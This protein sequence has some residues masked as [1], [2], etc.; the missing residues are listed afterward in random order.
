MNERRLR[1]QFEGRAALSNLQAAEVAQV[2]FRAKFFHF[3]QLC[4]VKRAE[5]AQ[6]RQGGR[7]AGA[8]F[9]VAV[10]DF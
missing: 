4:F 3:R 6:E 2:V 10:A 7:L 5:M 8:V 1:F 9:R